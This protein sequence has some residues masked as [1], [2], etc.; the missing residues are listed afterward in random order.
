[1]IHLVTYPASL[2]V[3]SPSPFCVKAAFLL[4]LSGQ[5]WQREDQHDPR[6]MPHGK[7]PCIRVDGKVI[8]DSDAIRQYL[9]ENGAEF[10]AGLSDTEKGLSRALIRMFEDHL[11]FHLMLDRWGDDKVWPKINETYFGHLPPVIRSILPPLLRRDVLKGLHANGVSRF[12]PKDRARRVDQDLT[13]FSDLLQDKPFV[14]GDKPTAIDCTAAAWLGGARVSPLP[15]DLS[16]R[17]ADDAKLVA[18]TDRVE[19]ALPIM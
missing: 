5:D 10:D 12:S 15:T 18:Y 11:Y 13:A 19:E 9:E 17:V 4:Q 14:F 6:K 7:L 1:M 16:R 3:F 2:G 8:G